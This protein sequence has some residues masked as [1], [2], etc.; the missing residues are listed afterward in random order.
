MIIP[1]GGCT[2]ASLIACAYI[3]E[4]PDVSKAPPTHASSGS[5]QGSVT[6]NIMHAERQWACCPVAS[7]AWHQDVSK[8]STLTLTHTHTHTH[9]RHYSRNRCVT[10]VPCCHPHPHSA[11]G[12]IVSEP[13]LAHMHHMESKLNPSF[14]SSSAAS[15]IAC[16]YIEEYPDVSKAPPTQIGHMEYYARRTPVGLLSCRIGCL[17]PGRF[18]T[19]NTHT[20]SHSHTHT[21]TH[22]HTPLQP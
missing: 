1:T 8:Q 7:A 16:A 20:H 18:Q 12:P 15:L 21:H 22:T 17:A 14:G 19:V 5:V 13:A 11:Q 10:I 4:Y 2:A 9:T 6:W 3:E